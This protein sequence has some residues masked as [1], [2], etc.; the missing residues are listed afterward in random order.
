MHDGECFLHRQFA[1]LLVHPDAVHRRI[2][3]PLE[4]RSP[5]LDTG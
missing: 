1:R 2:E 5:Q 4:R 3:P